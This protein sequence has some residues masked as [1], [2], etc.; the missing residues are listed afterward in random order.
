MINLLKRRSKEGHVW[1]LFVL[2]FVNACQPA[3][4]VSPLTQP[5]ST[6]IPILE[7]TS[8]ETVMPFP[9]FELPTATPIAT[10]FTSMLT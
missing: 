4:T 8:T 7:P 5:T 9:T 3:S 10:E 1:M 6:Q 2:F